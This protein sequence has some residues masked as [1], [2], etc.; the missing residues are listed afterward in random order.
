MTKHS[1]MDTI[2]NRPSQRYTEPVANKP[3]RNGHFQPPSDL[4]NAPNR[5]DS[6][7]AG[8][9]FKGAGPGSLAHGGGVYSQAPSVMSGKS[10]TSRFS[11]FRKKSRKPSISG[12]SVY[13]DGASS[14][15]PTDV[16]ASPRKGRW[17]EGGSLTRKQYSRPPSI[18]GSVFS[19]PEAAGPPGFPRISD[20]I[21]GSAAPRGA[22]SDYGGPTSSRIRYSSQTAPPPL[23]QLVN[24]SSM[25]SMR[26]H[27]GVA[28]L[29]QQQP[30]L[31]RQ[32][33]SSSM[34]RSGSMVTANDDPTRPV[35]PAASMGRAR[36]QKRVA[37][38]GSSDWNSFVK[39]MSGTEVAK[40]WETM[41]TLAPKPPRTSE[42]RSS[43]VANRVKKELEQDAQYQQVQRD[44]G[45]VQQ[46]LLARAASQVIGE[47]PPTPI[48][49]LSE[50]QLAAVHLQ[51][52][53]VVAPISPTY[54][55]VGSSSSI[56]VAQYPT[57]MSLQAS[58]VM[59]GAGAPAP[60]I[61]PQSAAPVPIIHAPQQQQQQQQQQQLQQQ[62]YVHP[63]AVSYQ[64]VEAVPA[65]PPQQIVPEPNAVASPASPPI[66]QSPPAQTYAPVAVP[67][68]RSVVESPVQP[69]FV[70]PTPPLPTTAVPQPAAQVSAE[71]LTAPIAPPTTAQYLA[72]RIEE[73]ESPDEQST[74]EENTPEE[75]EESDASSDEGLVGGGHPTLD[76][77]AEEE[78]ESSSIG[79]N[80]HHEMRS[81]ASIKGKGPSRN[82]DDF[83]ARLHQRQASAASRQDDSQDDVIAIAPSGV[84]IH[85]TEP[86]EVQQAPV[87]K[88][89]TQTVVSTDMP[90]PPTREVPD[91]PV[92]QVVVPT[93]EPALEQAQ[94][95]SQLAVA[96][97]RPQLVS[98]ASEVSDYQSATSGRSTPTARVNSEETED[99]DEASAVASIAQ[100]RI[101]TKPSDES[102]VADNASIAPS[103]RPSVRT[104]RSSRPG[105]LPRRLSDISLGTSFAVSG[106]MRRS[107]SSM[108]RLGDDDSDSGA[109]LSDDD[110][111]LRAKALAEQDRLRRMNVGED[112]FGPSLSGILDKFDRFSYSDTTVNK[113][114][115]EV[116]EPASSSVQPTRDV[117]VA[118]NSN[119]EAEAQEAINEVRQK[120]ADAA[121]NGTEGKR[122]NSADTGLAPSFAAVWLLNQA[123]GN[124]NPSTEKQAPEETGD[125]TIIASSWSKSTPSD[126]VVASGGLSP[127]QPKV[128]VLD[129]PRPKSKRPNEMGGLAISEGRLDAQKPQ[130]P[131]EDTRSTLP[132]SLSQSS[133]QSAGSAT[134]AQVT[135]NKASSGMVSSKDKPAPA[136]SAMKPKPSRSLADTLFGIN[137]RSPGKEKKE[138][139][140]KEKKDK[141]D[142]SKHSRKVSV[143]S[144][145][146]TSNKS[147]RSSLVDSIGRHSSSDS[148]HV[149]AAASPSASVPGSP[150]AKALGKQRVLDDAT[151][152]PSVSSEAASAPS[153]MVPSETVNQFATPLQSMANIQSATVSPEKFHTA[154]DLKALADSA[155]PVYPTEFR[156]AAVAQQE[157]VV[158]PDARP[159]HQRKLSEQM[160]AMDGFGSFE[161]P[162][163]ESRQAAAPGA[164]LTELPA[165]P[166]AAPAAES[167]PVAEEAI[168]HVNE[169]QADSNVAIPA[170]STSLSVPVRE[171]IVEEAGSVPTSSEAS[172]VSTALT[173]PENEAA[174]A[175]KQL[176]AEKAVVTEVATPELPPAIPSA[177]SVSEKKL[178]LPPPPAVED[179][180]SVAQEDRTPIGK[181]QVVPGV[182]I[183]LIPPTPPAFESRN[184]YTGSQVPGTPTIAEHVDDVTPQ[185]PPLMSRSSSQ[186]TAVRADSMPNASSDS[187]SRSKS[188]APARKGIWQE[189]KG[190]GL[191]LPPGLVATTID[192]SQLRRM[193]SHG[194]DKKS[195]VAPAP[196]PAPASVPAAAAPSM[197]AAPVIGQIVA[198]APG[199]VLES[200]PRPV[201]AT[202]SPSPKSKRSSVSSAPFPQS[203][204]MT[205]IMADAPPVPQIPVGYQGAGSVS[206][207]SS[208]L[209]AYSV[210]SSEQGWD[211]RS[212]SPAPSAVPSQSGRSVAS[213]VSSSVHSNS[214]R[215]SPRPEYS[216][217]NHHDLSPYAKKMR[218]LSPSP[219][220]PTLAQTGNRHSLMSAINEWESQVPETEEVAG[221]SPYP[222]RP[223]SPQP[224][225]P[226]PASTVSRGS[227]VISAVSSPAVVRNAPLGASTNQYLHPPI[228]RSRMS[229]DELPAVTESMAESLSPPSVVGRAESVSSSSPS[230]SQSALSL[231]STIPTSMPTVPTSYRPNKD[232]KRFSTNVDDLLN[233]R[234]TM[235]TVA[236]TSGA[237][238]GKSK[239]VVKR[240][241]SVD[242]NGDR[243]A[244]SDLPEHL[245]DDLS[246]TTLSITAHT[247]PPR[248]I[249]SHQVLVQVI[250][251]AID[252]TDKL[253]LREKV[254]GDSAFGFV[255]GRSFCGRI[256][257]C[258]YEV[259]KMRK[260]DVVFGLQ[261]SR[262]SG[263]L[264]EF[265]VVDHTRICHAPSDCLTTE[266]IA[267]LP[268]AGVM[269]HQLVQNHCRQL[270]R[271]ARVLI[272][273]AHDGVGLLT[274]QES[275]GL[276]LVIVAQCPPSVS[277]GV[278]VCQANG[279]HEVVIGEPLW[280]INSLHESSFD[281][282]VDTVGGRKI[283][284]ASR[285]I[286]AFDGQYCTCFGDEHGTANPNLKSHF[287]SLRRAFFKKDK[288]NI[289]YE[290]VGVDTG[291]DCKEALE[292]VKR[293]AEAGDICPRLR[294]VLPFADAP[295]AFDPTTRN[296]ND[297]PGAIVVRVS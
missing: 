99:D 122:R 73:E 107:G 65:L 281:L 179:V 75:S 235:Q 296:V 13:Y 165:V 207:S 226:L 161:L 153:A 158:A 94:A 277:D 101:R 130:G 135:P 126:T 146:S 106:I 272:L 15:A 2:L 43:M 255:P 38:S 144:I 292:A 5:P 57:S 194:Q 257:E 238:A 280:A 93:A 201:R 210:A 129:R 203:A 177:L 47:M 268:S 50:P 282:I 143:D 127:D 114:S 191:S 70:A 37:A 175:V 234:T 81:H 270:Q 85:V 230:A 202:S 263:A 62:Q 82:Y 79:H 233:N 121:S 109:E 209:H 55:P 173:S 229:V 232:P 105:T 74:P 145:G 228:A 67:A 30:N 265:M 290:W 134:G 242:L 46:D 208:R 1:F 199:S 184:S 185:R 170:P 119:I 59:Y 269:A 72:D 249:G 14:I 123:Q 64:S 117:P 27:S 95:A 213:H 283:Y 253:L 120:R 68:P 293:A 56:N 262:K 12:G 240:K 22:R 211:S 256:V 125:D 8:N 162:Q 159:E 89:V 288:K 112:F 132:M 29:G 218:A 295:R 195:H 182:G 164:E 80:Y 183:N 273:N 21:K 241:K 133:F 168:A 224:Y 204:S 77:V 166:E 124:D 271:G 251:V 136:K 289:G 250:A 25:S 206:S 284:D 154:H 261:D 113:L 180:M 103:Q 138:K 212:V 266:Q 52:G 44:P 87:S 137:F 110:A 19:E 69:G 188:M 225:P 285:R 178:P 155:I 66:P 187:L 6:I 104:S 148:A 11:V 96:A 227:S 248:K 160:K 61:V 24:K 71:T 252:E 149:P 274:M 97:E 286:L 258:G 16:S 172:L 28:P 254:R 90:E 48:S 219:A 163:L 186:R 32:T 36:S 181:P 176:D 7:L 118:K 192:S 33:S 239:S 267:A 31:M 197:P 200:P 88:T 102:I 222:S 100:V 141:K 169:S 23:P 259:K 220:V 152:V 83:E 17:W 260:G 190:K 41:P 223:V 156:N 205:R 167:A 264:A 128:S 45:V 189:Y 297:E 76:V 92:A 26:R 51:P 108:R 131:V 35:S 215:S 98:R 18:A 54:S 84:Q 291:E 49:P 231:A 236:V 111:E 151:S 174:A 34:T 3:S 53:H 157:G 91:A 58:A 193:S 116:A 247:P 276:G 246:L 287:R 60:V 198:H 237:F 63:Q 279:A 140:E 4:P 214:Y 216:Y 40:M 150:S 115:R 294:S 86:T 221:L 245:Q 142:K 10:N 275:V 9:M 243:R 147:D 42:K 78:E 171:E 139:R 20:S 244:S 39:S 196:T 217:V 278:A